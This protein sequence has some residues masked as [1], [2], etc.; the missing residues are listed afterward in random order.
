[1]ASS[2]A[3]LHLRRAAELALRGRLRVEPNPV[4]GCVLVRAGRVVGEG[5]HGE[6]GGA[7]AEV[8]AIRAAGRRAK[9][10][11]A[12][13]T[14]EP[15]GHHGKTPPCTEALLAA[16]IRAVVYAHPDPN[17]Q[18]AGRGP[19]RL[20]A[21]GVGVRRLRPVA[22]IRE[23]LEPY[24]A[25][26]RRRRP[27]VI[28]KWAM[29][30][31]GRTAAASGDSRWISGHEARAL[32][33]AR[34]RA[35]VDAILIGAGTLR[36]DDPALTNRSGTG[37]RPLRV[38]VGGARPLPSRARLFRDG[39]PT[40]LVLPPG[41]P[42]PRG[43]PHLVC[44]R[45]GRVDLPRLL[46]ELRRRGVERLLVEGGGALLGSLFDARLVDQVAATVSP[47]IV[48]GQHAPGPV[49]GRGGRRMA[50]AL[51]LR[52]LV[53]ASVGKDLIVEGLIPR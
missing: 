14:L 3:S 35:S 22:L 18:T 9:G 40:L 21:A 38:V 19:A 44:G 39:G 49:G 11:T 47:R 43:V 8:N 29:T 42:P 37:G 27:W 16:G 15:C 13:V 36:A 6:W 25:H 4:V 34:F 28:A 31:D 10:A 5:W 26:R 7:H 41:R 46:R 17:P 33:H 24:L 50:D 12:Y 2:P 32:A 53:V 48:G 20:R 30:L 52:D 51:A 45:E 1:M 23:Q